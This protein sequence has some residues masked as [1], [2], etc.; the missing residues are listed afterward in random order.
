MSFHHSSTHVSHPHAH[1]SSLMDTLIHG[2]AWRAGSR[3]VD[4]LFHW[5]PTLAVAA[6]ICAV[7]VYGIYRWRRH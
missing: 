2:A 6:V 1:Q 7:I 3:T 4:E 5:A